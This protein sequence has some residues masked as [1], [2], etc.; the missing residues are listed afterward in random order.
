MLNDLAS[1]SM[2][3]VWGSEKAETGKPSIKRCSGRDAK[4][5]TALCMAKW[6]ARRMLM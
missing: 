5:D 4:P 3:A 2:I 1:P 6:V